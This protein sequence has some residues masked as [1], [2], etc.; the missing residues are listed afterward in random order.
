MGEVV[1]MRR[2]SL[3]NAISFRFAVTL[4]IAG[5]ATSAGA[6]PLDE[7]DRFSG[8]WQ[9]RGTFVDTPYSKAHS[10]AGTTTCAWSDDHTFMICQQRVTQYGD[11]ETDVA[12]YTYDDATKTYRFSNIQ[13][14]Q[15]TSLTI[16]VAE[17]TITYP[18][19]F[20][21]NG[22]NVNVRTLNVWVSPNLYRWR[23][24]YSLDGGTTW[25]PMASGTSQR[26]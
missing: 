16:T 26:Q 18:L 14:Q 7:L 2:A 22:K 4:A 1:L 9:S 3:L 12:V 25:K 19:A 23:T 15:T 20:T 21:D 10:A 13:R 17:N 5:S 11:V 24:E 6:A 8:T